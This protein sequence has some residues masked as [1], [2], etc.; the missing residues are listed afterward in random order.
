MYSSVK[1]VKTYVD[2]STSAATTALN[3]EISRATTA[4][5]LVAANLATEINRATAAENLKENSANK[6]T[7]GTM[8]SNS[9]IK[10]PTEKAVRTYVTNSSSIV[11]IKSVSANYTVTMNDYTILCDNSNGTFTLTLP[12][13]VSSIGKIFVI[14]KIDDTSNLLSFSPPLRFS[15][16][17]SIPNLNYTKTFK[18]QSDGSS[19]FIIN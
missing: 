12:N 8:A 7:D 9:D 18:V 11:S 19:W 10:F 1:S 2:A 3:S 15:L 16:N 4:E 5:N 6:S 17:T 13:V 14:S